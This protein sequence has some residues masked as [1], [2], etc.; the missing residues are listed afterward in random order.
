MAEEIKNN[1]F[2]SAGFREDKRYFPRWQVKN[3]IVY[4]FEGQ[5]QLHN[6]QSCDL[7]CAGVSLV[8][9]FPLVPGQKLKLRIYLFEDKSVEVKGH[10]VWV[11]ETEEGY[12]SGVHFTDSTTE[13]QNKIL[14]YAFEIKKEDVVNHWFE[15]WKK[16]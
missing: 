1:V 8:S 4:H 12:L 14:E 5:I 11:R 3:R 16:K 7:S 15:G 2:A 13:V 9:Q 10:P 6:A